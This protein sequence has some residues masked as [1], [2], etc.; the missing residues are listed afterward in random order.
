MASHAALCLMDKP[1]I[2][3][4]LWKNLRQ[5]SGVTN[6][7]KALRPL[8][9]SRGYTVKIVVERPDI[10]NGKGEGVDLAAYNPADLY[11]ALLK[12]SPCVMVTMN[13]DNHAAAAY[14]LSKSNQNGACNH[15]I[16]IL[17]ADTVREYYEPLQYFD[18]HVHAFVA[19]SER[20]RREVEKRLPWR[21]GQ[22][23][24]MPC[25][26]PCSP[27]M[28]R[29][30]HSGP[31]RIAYAGR[32][33]QHQKRVL[34]F[35]PFVAQLQRR[36][37]DF[38]LMI[39]GDGPE[40]GTLKKALKRKSRVV[41]AG[42][43]RYE[44]MATVWED[45]DVFLNLSAFEG[46]SVSMLEAMASGCVPVV[47][48]VSGVD[49]V[50]T[51]SANG[52]YA[53]VGNITGL[54]D[55]IE[56]L[57]R[58][59][60][61]LSDLAAGAHRT[62]LNT[63]SL[64]TYSDNFTALVGRITSEDPKTVPGQ[65]AALPRALPNG[66]VVVNGSSHMVVY[67]IYSDEHRQLMDKYFIGTMRDDW[68]VYA[69]YA[70]NLGGTKGS[71]FGSGPYFD[72]L[73]RRVGLVIRS[74]REHWNKIVLWI[75]TDV[76]FFGRFSKVV[77][78]TLAG[79]DMVFQSEWSH[80][81][82]RPER[83][84]CCGL[85]AM[86][87]NE[88]VLG[89]WEKV[90]ELMS[91]PDIDLSHG[92]QSAVNLILSQNRDVVRWTVFD[93]RIWAMSHGNMPLIDIIAHHANCTEPTPQKSS[94]ELKLEQFEGVRF[95]IDILLLDPFRIHF[96][97]VLQL[98]KRCGVRKVLC[99]PAGSGGREFV[100]LAKMDGLKVAAVMDSNPALWGTDIFGV[101]VISPKEAVALDLDVFAISSLL[102]AEEITEMIYGMYRKKKRRLPCIL[103]APG[104]AY[105][106]HKQ[107]AAL[108]DYRD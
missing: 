97:P 39:V 34:D 64:E 1:T 23:P 76:Q 108:K 29:P 95:Y 14:A 100:R 17:H 99:S 13:I 106:F 73:K 49:D 83:Q 81:Q 27:L 93:S 105:Q 36:N 98:A 55:L 20:I 31:L 61:L 12:W 3:F 40:L 6:W 107:I 50:I 42:Q 84:V 74:I 24:V 60:A 53:P 66:D 4:L 10:T 90:L 47:T 72:L 18:R 86:R 94:L 57:D 22:V 8:L 33:I 43:L 46:T 9:E 7:A 11:E 103:T 32:I 71:N 79:Y 48:E 77:E 15:I 104:S 69:H 56:Q 35:I 38:R 75:D 44:D 45:N 80:F 28:N 52:L 78:D 85:M 91:T 5:I 63:Y 65:I 16:S 70:G 37:I 54:A 96:N 30:V 41:F 101:P 2:V 21:S 26:V 92:D 87:C 59:R 19:V 51:Q 25:G 67:T 62:V 58:D 68:K 89:F 102:Y 88:A 82:N